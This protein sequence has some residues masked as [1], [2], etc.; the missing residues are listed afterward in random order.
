MWDRAD[1]QLA[2]LESTL[3]RLMKGDPVGYALEDINVRYAELATTLSDELEDIKFGKQSDEL[4]LAG[5]WTTYNDARSFMIIGDPAVR[6]P[7]VEEPAAERPVMAPVV[8]SAPAAG[9]EPDQPLEAPIPEL[10]TTTPAP[11]FQIRS[12]AFTTA[13][14]E[15]FG[16]GDLFGES[17]VRRAT[18]NLF[19]NVTEISR[20]LERTLDELSDSFAVETWVAGDATDRPDPLSGE[21]ASLAIV[22]RVRPDGD[23]QVVFSQHWEEMDERLW[24]MHCDAVREAQASRAE[25]LQ[26]LA[27]ALQVLLTV[28]P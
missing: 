20:V 28:S 18:K 27:S 1:T 12:E 3:T 2:V 23:T 26:V 8:L 25:K 7:V 5:M 22:T 19:A 16:L 17:E 6:L 9:P 4:E 24:R 13:A 21:G 15:D 11:A 10:P 14:E